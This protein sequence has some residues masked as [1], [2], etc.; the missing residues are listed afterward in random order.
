M[1]KPFREVLETKGFI[2]TAELG[3]GKGSNT[4]KL[5]E[6]IELL[7]GMVDALNVTDNQSSVMR[8][9]SIGGCLLIKE[10]G[11]EPIL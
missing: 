4:S 1:A 3:P 10:H 6:H 2:V 9:S 11:G 5:I 7:K 8:Y